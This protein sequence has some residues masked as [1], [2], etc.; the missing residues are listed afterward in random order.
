MYFIIIHS[1]LFE[2]ILS[3]NRMLYKGKKRY[4]VS[5]YIIESLEPKNE[6][7]RIKQLGKD[8]HVKLCFFM[9]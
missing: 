5:F 3:V 6:R 9:E 2:N 1:S 4:A 8:D 7:S